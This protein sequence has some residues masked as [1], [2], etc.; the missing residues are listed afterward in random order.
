MSAKAKKKKE[1]NP[2]AG[3]KLSRKTIKFDPGRNRS[4]NSTRETIT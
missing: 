4:I 1:E 2:V 3:R